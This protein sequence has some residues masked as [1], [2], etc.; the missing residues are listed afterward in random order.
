MR[1]NALFIESLFS[2]LTPL[3]QALPLVYLNIAFLPQDQV[4]DFMDSP[5]PYIIGMNIDTWTASAE[6]KYIKLQKEEL[7][8]VLRF[9]G[10]QPVLN[11]PSCNEQ[12]ESPSLELEEHFIKSLR[13][14]SELS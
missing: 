8:A 3:L 9:E 6:A 2:L 10:D 7:I 5:V 13:L 12:C 1:R 11:F 14:I 4:S